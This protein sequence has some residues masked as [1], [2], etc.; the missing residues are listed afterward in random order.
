M[1]RGNRDCAGCGQRLSE[2][3]RF[4]P[5]CSTPQESGLPAGGDGVQFH[6]QHEREFLRDLHLIGDNGGRPSVRERLRLAPSRH[7]RLSSGAGS[8]PLALLVGGGIL[9][10]SVMR[11]GE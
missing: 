10:L 2:V 1:P 8:P 6:R 7:G 5:D 4:C 9:V 11:R 3:Y